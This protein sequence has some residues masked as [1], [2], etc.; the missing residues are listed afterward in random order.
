LILQSVVLEEEQVAVTVTI[1]RSD[2]RKL[3]KKPARYRPDERPASCSQVT[4]LTI[5]ANA[6]EFESRRAYERSVW[7]TRGV[8]RRNCETR[9]P[10]QKRA[11]TLIKPKMHWA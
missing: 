8:K 4:S 9:S 5:A 10:I 11:L 6:K 7:M 1:A 3:R 2:R